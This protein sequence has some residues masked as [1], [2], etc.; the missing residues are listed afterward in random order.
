MGVPAGYRKGLKSSTFG[1]T[2]SNGRCPMISNVG[3]PDTDGQ[4]IARADNPISAHRAATRSN[5][6]FI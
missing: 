3:R 5:G 2:S 6:T 4:S 1:A